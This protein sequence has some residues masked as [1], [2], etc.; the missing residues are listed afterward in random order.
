MR[1]SLTALILWFLFESIA[2]SLWLTMDN[3]FYLFNFSYIGTCLALGIFLYTKKLKYARNMVQFAVGLYM[4]FYLGIFSK[5]NMQI[6]GFWYYLFLGVFEAAVIH[7]AVA[8][9]FGPLF[10][11]RG[12]CG[13][14]CWTA[15]VL[16]L[17]PYKI[18][19]RPRKKL[20]FLR[21]ITFAL[22]LLFVTLLFLTGVP[23]KDKIIYRSFLIGN[24]LYY[25]AGI[26]LAFLYRDNRAFCKYI[27]PV[28]V[29]L[30]PASYFSLLRIKNDKTKCVSCGRCR[31]ICPMNVDM[32]DNARRRR[33]G[34]ECILCL[35]CIEECPHK[36]LYLS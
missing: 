9:L 22:S 27:C 20:G 19:D 36:A 15:M 8:K 3:P 14:A 18:P 25:T 5:E 33:N 7:Y 13:Y 35:Q 30:K 6:E 2:V 31:K 11:G 1:K 34:T 4:L 21:Y 12:W 17:L 23:E 10:F 26:L 16:D 29:F 24:L 32:T 28:T